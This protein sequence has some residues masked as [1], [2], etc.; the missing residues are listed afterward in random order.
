MTR[1][2]GR[3]HRPVSA[4][5]GEFPWDRLGPLREVAAEHP[6]GV[7]DLSVGTPVD[8]TPAVAQAALAAAADAPGYPTTAG[9]VELRAA[10]L[11]WLER[12]FGVTG[13]GVGAVVPSIGLKEMVASLALHLGLGPGDLV[14][15][16][17][18]AYPT[19]EVGARLAGCDVAAADSLTALGPARPALVW[20]NSPSNPT[21]R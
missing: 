20:V 9:T 19:Y 15:V 7:V 6:D 14:V 21:G 2:G 4:R 17:E 13:V 12:R 18:L 1:G 5:L 16:P 10:L 11:G 3:P 8:S